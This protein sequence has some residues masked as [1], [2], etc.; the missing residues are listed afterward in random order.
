MEPNINKQYIP[1]VQNTKQEHIGTPPIVNQK[2][3]IPLILGVVILLIVVAGGAY[4]LGTK[5]GNLIT[6]QQTN[7]L[8]TQTTNNLQN[9]SPTTTTSA[10]RQHKMELYL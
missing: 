4:Y 2:G 3:F 6:S 10:L 7:P 1:P 8:P 9:V 5:K